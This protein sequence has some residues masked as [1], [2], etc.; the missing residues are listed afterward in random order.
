MLSGRST[1]LIFALCA[2]AWVVIV[3]RAYMNVK[4]TDAL[5]A[6]VPQSE[7][8]RFAGQQLDALQAASFANDQELC[9]IIFETSEG[10]LGVSRPTSGEQASC[11]LLF[12][13]E[14]GMVPVASIHTH[15][16]HSSQYDAEVPST[17]DIRSDVSS[18]I[19][20]YIS[21]PGGRLW[22][23]DHETGIA[24]LACGEGCLDQDPNYRPCPSDLIEETY[25]I[26]TLERRF[27][28]P[29]RNC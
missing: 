28:R 24:R 12:F 3:G 27:M 19:D 26:A 29:I 11:D 15:G 10:E 7:V 2:L 21:T 16:A 1:R 8:Q 6:T 17:I 13:D 4:G 22:H 9:G 14:P 18:G 25:S 23:V 20:G 5:V